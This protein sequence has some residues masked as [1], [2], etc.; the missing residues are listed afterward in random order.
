MLFRFRG[1]C[2]ACG[3][4]W[5]GLRRQIQ[6]G[7]IDFEEPESFE[8]YSCAKCVCDVYVPRLESRS[9]WLRWV[10]LNASEMTRSPLQLNACELGVTIDLQQL[11]VIARSAILFQASERISCILSEARSKY[12]PTAIDVGPMNCPDCTEPLFRGELDAQLLVC[13]TCENRSAVWASEIT[14]ARVL[15]DYSPLDQHEVRRIVRHLEEL[16]EP[17]KDRLSKHLLAL[18]AA[19]A[20]APLWDRQLDG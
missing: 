10:R 2:L 17:P 4:E 13:P 3:H 20:T 19:E 5:N 11:E 16:A 12:L 1:E 15:V 6:C 14:P 9:S 7:P 18:P 8:S